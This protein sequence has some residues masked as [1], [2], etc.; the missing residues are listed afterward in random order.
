MSQTTQCSNNNSHNYLHHFHLTC[1]S[2]ASGH[3]HSPGKE[4]WKREAVNS[5]AHSFSIKGLRP[6]ASYKVR[7][8][9]RDPATD[10]TV[11]S[12]EEELVSVPGEAACLRPRQPELHLTPP[13][14]VVVVAA[15]S[16]AV[17][18]R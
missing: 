17:C 18:G 4:E 10:A 15:S 11:H 6:G 1:R 16:S 9:A 3:A 14:V 7:V 8:V 2:S 12:T 13:L 5:S